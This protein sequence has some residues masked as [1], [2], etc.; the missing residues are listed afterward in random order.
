MKTVRFGI[1]GVG[2]MGGSHANNF[3]EG[4]IPRARLAAVSDPVADLSRFASGTKIFNSSE[5]M[6]RS[7][8]M[9]S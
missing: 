3:L 8:E 5:E 6:I 2:A 1:A 9:R 4:K 7:G